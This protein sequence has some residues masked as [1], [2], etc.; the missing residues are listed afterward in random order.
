MSRKF[1]RRGGVMFQNFPW[2]KLGEINPVSIFLVVG[3]IFSLVLILMRY[4]PIDKKRK[5]IKN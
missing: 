3:V 5:Q 4:W 1:F 2:D